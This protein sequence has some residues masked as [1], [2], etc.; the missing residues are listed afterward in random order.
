MEVLDKISKRLEKIDVDDYVISQAWSDASHVKFANSKIVKTGV[1]TLDL[2]NLFVTKKKR[3]VTTSIHKTDEKSINKIVE[4]V[5]KFL[6]LVPENKNYRGIAKGPFK[7]NEI[8]DSFDKKV[9]KANIV[10]QVKKAMGVAD[11]LGIKRSAGVLD[12]YDINLNLLT[13]NNIKISDKATKLYFSI[14][15]H[16]NKDASGHMTACSRTLSKFYVEDAA[17]HAARIANL[18]R[19]RKSL[20]P[21]KYDIIFEPLPMADLLNPVMDSASVF[22][23][24][25]NI[26]FFKGM[27]NK[28][29]AS[30]KVTLVDDATTRNGFNSSKFDAEGVPAQ[31]TK[32]INNRRVQ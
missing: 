20:N 31:K 24:E 18:V 8:K 22:S 15:C 3:I 11:N 27:L 28:K 26:S 13:S 2:I 9:S 12:S 29:V 5:R 1:E 6:R 14:R 19:E 17:K 7:Y 16:K 25:A 32:I 30:D 21:G 10:E 23:V 4:A